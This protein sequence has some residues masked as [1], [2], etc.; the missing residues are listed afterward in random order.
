MT[1]ILIFMIIMKSIRQN[2]NGNANS[3]GETILAIVEEKN[4]FSVET[5][6]PLT[7]SPSLHL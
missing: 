7:F 3:I 4:T 1:P 2:Q 6:V 5:H